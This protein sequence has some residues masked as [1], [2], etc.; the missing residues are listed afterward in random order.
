MGTVVEKEGEVQE[1]FLRR[2][3]REEIIVKQE[4]CN[5]REMIWRKEKDGV[6]NLSRR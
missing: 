3:S 1:L 4:T 2:E 6:M 5:F